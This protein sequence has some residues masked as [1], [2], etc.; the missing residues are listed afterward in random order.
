MPLLCNFKNGTHFH[1]SKITLHNLKIIRIPNL[2]GADTQERYLFPGP[3]LVVDVS[4]L[5]AP[6]VKHY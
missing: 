5:D 6:L 3:Y 4:T 2:R 1:D